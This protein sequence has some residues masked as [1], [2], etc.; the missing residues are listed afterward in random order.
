MCGLC[1]P[2]SSRRIVQDKI[3]FDRKEAAN[4]MNN[5]GQWII[6]LSDYAKVFQIIAHTL[7]YNEAGQLIPSAAEELDFI[8]YWKSDKDFSKEKVKEYWDNC[9]LVDEKSFTLEAVKPSSGC[10]EIISNYIGLGPLIKF[11]Q[12]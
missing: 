8:S 12:S 5:C 9:K 4:F 1:S 6:N 11:D 10:Q 3:F 7:R 2:E